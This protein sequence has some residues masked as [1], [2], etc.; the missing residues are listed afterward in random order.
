[1]YI[2][3]KFFKLNSH[4]LQQHVQNFLSFFN[5]KMREKI[6]LNPRTF[7]FLFYIVQRADAPK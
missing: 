2:S 5:V 1:M 6:L 3:K 7:L 4:D